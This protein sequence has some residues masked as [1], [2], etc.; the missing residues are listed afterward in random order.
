MVLAQ[1][2][3]TA[4]YDGMRRSAVATGNVDYILLVNE[5]PEVLI[6]YIEH[7]RRHGGAVTSN[8]R[9]DDFMENI[10][11][12]LI[13]RQ[14][15]DFRCYKRGTIN[16]RVLQRMGLNHISSLEDYHAKLRKDDGEVRALAKDLLIGIVFATDVD[17]EALEVARSGIYTESLVAEIDPESRFS[18]FRRMPEEWCTDAPFTDLRMAS[19]ELAPSRLLDPGIR[20][21][22]GGFFDLSK[23]HW[24]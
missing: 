24:A 3:T 1:D 20:R 15:Y 19:R 22:D 9:D 14:D 11:A 7:F 4:G 10:L 2:P 5:M 8:K 16:R 6:S 18:S 17:R 21:D 12:L 23:C 13:A